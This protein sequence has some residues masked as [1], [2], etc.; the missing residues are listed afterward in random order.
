MRSREY[1]YLNRIELNLA[2]LA[3]GVAKIRLKSPI[4]FD[5]EVSRPAE[6]HHQPLAEPDVTLSRHPAPII[7][8][9]S[10]SEQIATA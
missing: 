10:P 5:R 4:C 8:R 9:H 6:F 2:K 7:H 3:E 1:K